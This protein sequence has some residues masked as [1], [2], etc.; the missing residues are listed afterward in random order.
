MKLTKINSNKIKKAIICKHV[1]SSIINKNIKKIYIPKAGD[2]AVFKVKEIGKHTRIQS[3]GGNNKYILPGD[4]IMAAFGNRYATGQ[5]EGHI[6]KSYQ[7]TYHILGQGGAIG[8]INSIHK[9]FE[10]I[11]PATLSLVGYVVNEEGGVINT[12]YLNNEISSENFIRIHRKPKIIL[13]LGTSMDSGK[14]TSA[15]YLARGLNLAGK[16][17]IF[18]KLTGTVFTKDKNFVKD[19]GARMALDFSDFGFPSTYMCSTPELLQLF[20]YLLEK[21]KSYDSEYIIVEIADGLLQRETSALIHDKKFR[22]K[23]NVVLFSSADSMGAISGADLLTNLGFTVVGTTGLFTTSPMLIDEVEQQSN[24]K[25]LT[26]EDL[27]SKKIINTLEEKLNYSRFENKM[28]VN[29]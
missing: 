26:G 21:V 27:M 9:K 7:S 16:K 24:Y 5:M 23:V 13:S 28:A 1:K 17:T 6:P 12:K 11:G 19:Y 8:V 25:V 10:L 15:A 2:V 3:V 4:L 22:S 20:D 14:T 18:I 29:I